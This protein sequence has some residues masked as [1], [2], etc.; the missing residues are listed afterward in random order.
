[1]ILAGAAALVFMNLSAVGSFRFPS[2]ATTHLLLSIQLGIW[3]TAGLSLIALAATDLYK[4]KD[5]DSLLLF[6]W[7]IGTFLFAGFINWTLNARSILPMTIPAGIL[8]ARRLEIQGMAAGRATLPR[9][10]APLLAAFVVSFAVAWADTGFADTAKTAAA[11]IHASYGNSRV[12]W[13]QGHWGFQYYMEQLGAT[14]IDV[15]TSDAAAGDVVVVPTTNANLFEMGKNWPV[16]SIFEIAPLT[17][18]STTNARLGAGFYADVLGP[19]PFAVGTVPP[20][21]FTVFEIIP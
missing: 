7:T 19:L 1:L 15:R 16:R 3:G 10:L 17:W 11:K 18:L 13:F 14:P 21:R 20:E 9:P 5:A 6:L 8:I 2:D 12:V 4:N